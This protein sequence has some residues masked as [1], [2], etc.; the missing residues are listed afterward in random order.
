MLTYTGSRSGPVPQSKLQRSHIYSVEITPNQGE[1]PRQIK[2]LD[3]PIENTLIPDSDG[4]NF[5][6]N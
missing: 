5:V 2:L 1:S 3:N 4:T 6:S